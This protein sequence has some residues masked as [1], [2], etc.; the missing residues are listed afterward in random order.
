LVIKSLSFS[1]TE[2]AKKFEIE[3]KVKRKIIFSLLSIMQPFYFIGSI[4]KS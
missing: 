2:R 4:S 3:K 1:S